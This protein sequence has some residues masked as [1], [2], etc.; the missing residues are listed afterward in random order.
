MNGLKKL[1]SQRGE[2]LTEVLVALLV[3]ALAI[4]MLAGAI[5]S[6]QQ[7]I[8]HSGEV[9]DEYYAKNGYLDSHPQKGTDVPNGFDEIDFNNM[10]M[11]L[12]RGIKNAA[13]TVEADIND[14]GTSMDV[15]GYIHQQGSEYIVAYA[16]KPVE[17]APEG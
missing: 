9:M 8:R 1:S 12:R 14:E 16:K 5:V 15:I 13:G 11:E 2:S 7:M 3:G 4:T 17:P 10:K 6:S